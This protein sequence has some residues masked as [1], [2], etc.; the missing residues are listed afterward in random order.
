M[1]TV[2]SIAFPH[3]VMA[4]SPTQVLFNNTGGKF[5]PFAGQT[6]VGEMDFS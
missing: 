3:E 5:G 2:E 6:F 1:R 4:H